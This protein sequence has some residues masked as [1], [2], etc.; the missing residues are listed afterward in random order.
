[1]WKRYRIVGV[2]RRRTGSCE[3]VRS[4]GGDWSRRDGKC[5]LA[6]LFFICVVV[7]HSESGINSQPLC[8]S[9]LVR[10]P[11]RLLLYHHERQLECDREPDCQGGDTIT[12]EWELPWTISASDRCLLHLAFSVCFALLCV[13]ERTVCV[14][15]DMCVWHREKHSRSGGRRSQATREG[16]GCLRVAVTAPQPAVSSDDWCKNV[17]LNCSR[18]GEPVVV[19]VQPSLQ[20]PGCPFCACLSVRHWGW[21]W[22]LLFLQRG[23]Q[24]LEDGQPLPPHASLWSPTEAAA[25]PG[26]LLCHALY[27]W[28]LYGAKLRVILFTCS[29][30]PSPPS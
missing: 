28:G 16:A 19:C 6:H 17:C 25:L 27:H 22:P 8:H 30:A 10:L 21:R 24:S 23:T 26:S 9:V 1:V 18:E 29:S 7:Y 20:C 5:R 15:V 11:V 4:R 13:C 14:C 12:R 3:P 2:E